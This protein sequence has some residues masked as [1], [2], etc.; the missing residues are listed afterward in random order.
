MTL[1]SE[2]GMYEVVIRSDKSEAVSFRRWVTVPGFHTFDCPA[3]P[4][5]QPAK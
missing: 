5:P 1:V 3:S 4:Y 2:A